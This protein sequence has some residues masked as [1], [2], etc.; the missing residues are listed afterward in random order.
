MTH[1]AL[2]KTDLY[3]HPLCLGG[4]VFG[5]SSDEAQSFAV[6]NAYTEH[7][8]NFIDTA[9]VYSEWKD[10]NIGHDSE[11]ILG[12]WMKQKGNRAETV[13]ATK[14]AKLST[15]LGLSAANINAAVD[16]SL[17]ALQTDYID[18][19][20]SHEDDKTVP[21]RETLATYDALIK[22]GKVRYIAA[23]NYTGERLAEAI[24]IS[25]S[26]G[27][28]QYIALQNHYNLLDRSEYED[29]AAPVVL[30]EGISGIPYFGLARGFLSG[31]Y[32]RGE[33]TDS[34][35]AA[36]VAD[37]QNDRGY[38]VVALLEEISKRHGMPI[39]AVALGWLAAM[40]GVAT[41]I[42]SARTVE[43]LQEIVNFAQ[44]S[45]EEIAELSD[46]TA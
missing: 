40:P 38:Q 31:K 24:E 36:G 23:S 44:L 12:K 43:Q 28:A 21:L 37:Y 29:D 16:D 8:G 34:I 39:S 10:G 15:R 32:R 5:W 2:N 30:A 35:R 13:I 20:Y 11:A 26:E 17:R 9:D 45:S 19:Y 27:L 25:K 42:A 18:I 3:V 46:L 33:T 7:N 4:N 1:I 14:V 6:L 41:P 22:A